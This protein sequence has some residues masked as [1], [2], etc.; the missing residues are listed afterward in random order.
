MP[1]SPSTTTTTINTIQ[2][3]KTQRL[4]V[5]SSSS[6]S[7][8]RR[9]THTLLGLLPS[10]VLPHILSYLSAPKHRRDIHA[11]TLVN[12]WFYRIA[13]PLLYAVLETRS[14][15]GGGGG[16]GGKEKD[17]Q[18]AYVEVG[19]FSSVGVR[20]FLRWCWYWLRCFFGYHLGFWILGSESDGRTYGRPGDVHP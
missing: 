10:D 19:P 20:F 17:W 5:S 2:K 6:S 13:N 3:P 8:S 18:T 1:P 15:G 14:G 4:L 9:V 16:G 11:C 12:K 7:R